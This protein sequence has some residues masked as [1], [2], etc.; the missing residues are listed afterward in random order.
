LARSGQAAA[1]RAGSGERIVIEAPFPGLEAAQPV[2]ARCLI[3]DDDQAVRHAM[4][5]VIQGQGLQCLEASSAAEAMQL[6]EREGEVPLVISDVN[7]PGFD[8]VALL[9]Q[10]LKRWPDTAVIMLT[11]VADVRTAVLCLEKG[12]IDYIAKPAMMDEVRARVVKALEKRELKLQKRFYQR[13]LEDRVRQQAT[14]IKELFLEGVQTLAHALEAKDAYTRGHSR[15]VSR[16]AIKTALRMG[17]AGDYLEDIRLGGELHDIGK[18]GTREAVLNKPAALTPDEFA[19]ITEHTVLGER[20]LAPLARENPV[21]LRIV[22]SHHE[23]MDGRGF[24]DGLPGSSI[25]VEARIVAVVDAFDAMTTNRAYRESRS[26]D[27]A[28]EELRRCAGTHFDPDAVDAFLGAFPDP[29][30]LPLKLDGDAG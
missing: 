5:R 25:P 18:I 26:P 13:T 28:C 22:R 9:E 15:R 3:V 2:A 19:H 8:G 12:A 10:V 14:R 1:A 6:L 30:Q 29:K 24:P 17:F 7:M 16:Y 4:A 11:G 27:D 21:V 20:I 23:R